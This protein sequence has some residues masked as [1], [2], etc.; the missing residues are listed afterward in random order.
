LFRLFSWDQKVNKKTPAA[1]MFER[2]MRLP[3]MMV[4]RMLLPR[5][6]DVV[7]ADAC[8]EHIA[9]YCIYLPGYCQ[10][11]FLGLEFKMLVQHLP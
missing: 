6:C 3:L 9:Q 8:V 11:G 1:L 7:Q 4:V 10:S 5:V 2:G